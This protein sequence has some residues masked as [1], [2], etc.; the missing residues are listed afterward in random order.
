MVHVTV[1]MAFNKQ[2]LKSIFIYS[3][4]ENLFCTTNYPKEEE[5]EEVII[6][7]KGDYIYIVCIDEREIFIYDVIQVVRFANHQVTRWRTTF[8]SSLGVEIC[9]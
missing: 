8:H 6:C 4:I 5:E 3:E 7:V 9:K 1:C 2:M